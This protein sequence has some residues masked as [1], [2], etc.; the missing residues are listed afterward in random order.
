MEADAAATDIEAVVV[1]TT[2][3]DIEAMAATIAST[4]IKVKTD[5]AWQQRRGKD[6]I[7]TGLRPPLLTLRWC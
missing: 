1:A 6:H 2:A 7:A 5:T 4:D 3:A